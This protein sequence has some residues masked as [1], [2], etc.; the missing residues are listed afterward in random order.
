VDVGLGMRHISDC[1][2]TGRLD[3]KKVGGVSRWRM[4]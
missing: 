4:E 3:G 2:E 1:D